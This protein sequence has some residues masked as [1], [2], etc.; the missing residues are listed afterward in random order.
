MR[1][2]IW[3]DVVCPWCYIGKRRL[4]KALADF[5]HEVEV[6]WRSFQLDPGAPSE[7]TATVVEHLARKY[8]GG[9]VAAGRRMVERT[10]SVA[11][12]AGLRFDHADAPHV[13]TVDAHRL[14][15]LALETG[16]TALQGRVK[17]ALLAAYFVDARNVADHG[18]LREVTTGAGLDADAVDWVLASDRFTDEV[19]ADVARAQAYGASGVPFFVVDQKYGVSGAQPTELFTQVLERAWAD[20]H[21]AVEMVGAGEGDTCGPDGCAT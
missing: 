12:E 13:N 9:D 21:P 5:P 2:E 3:S 11:A 4:E 16:G 20:A 15:H 1:I 19:W 17:E 7:P 6:V 18:V 10:E 14:I 8:G